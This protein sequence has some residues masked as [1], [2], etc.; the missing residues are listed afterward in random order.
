MKIITLV[1]SLFSLSFAVSASENGRFSN[2]ADLIQTLNNKSCE[3]ILEIL[4]D[5]QG[6][7]TRLS[8]AAIKRLS[9][10]ENDKLG[11]GYYEISERAFEQRDAV[12]ALL[13]KKCIKE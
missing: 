9:I 13:I 3:S 4:L 12:K 6:E 2:T 10:N 1:I 5:R 7:G 8:S 11:L